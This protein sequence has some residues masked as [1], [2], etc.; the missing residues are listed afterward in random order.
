MAGTVRR[1]TPLEDAQ[2]F[3]IGSCPPLE[4]VSVRFDAA[5]GLVLAADVVATEQ[6][7]PFDNTAVDSSSHGNHGTLIG[8]AAYATDSAPKCDT[9]GASMQAVIGGPLSGATVLP[10]RMPHSHSVPMR[11]RVWEP[12]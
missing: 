6:V 10:Y 8:D 11:G 5:E 1:V 4:P 2:S 3:V 9:S 7:P 12:E